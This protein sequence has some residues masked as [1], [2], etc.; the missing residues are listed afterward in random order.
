MSLQPEARSTNEPVGFRPHFLTTIIDHPTPNAEIAEDRVPRDVPTCHG[1]KQR[2]TLKPLNRTV[3]EVQ[4][5]IARS[6]PAG[7]R[8][9]SFLTEFKSS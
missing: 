2:H 5:S 8:K 9:R 7:H 6:V 3:Q 1:T 4:R